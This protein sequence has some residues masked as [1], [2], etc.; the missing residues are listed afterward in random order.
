MLQL[1]TS[2]LE[3]YFLCLCKMEGYV[4]LLD[5][6]LENVDVVLKFIHLGFV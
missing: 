4:G 5:V 6:V 2:V 3:S 1:L